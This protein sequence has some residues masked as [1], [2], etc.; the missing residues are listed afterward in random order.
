MFFGKDS[1][2]ESKIWPNSHKNCFFFSPKQMENEVI[3][4]FPGIF[5]KNIK[6]M[7]LEV[8]TRIKTFVDV[9]FGSRLFSLE[10]KSK[11]NLGMFNTTHSQKTSNIFLFLCYFL[12]KAVLS[13]HFLCSL[14]RS[15][16]C[17][18]YWQNSLFKVQRSGL[19]WQLVRQRIPLLNFSV[20]TL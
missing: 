6:F 15:S 11:N 16:L 17:V 14:P 4:L 9:W 10:E 13:S 5:F 8:I 3:I 20:Q 18:Q 7:F 12:A 19:L 2:W 1:S